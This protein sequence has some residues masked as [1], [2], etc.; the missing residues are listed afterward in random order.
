MGEGAAKRENPMKK[1]LPPQLML[2]CLLTMFPLHWFFPGLTILP[3]PFQ[4]VGLLPLFT[5]TILTFAAEGQVRSVGTNVKTFNVIES[6]WPTQKC[7][8]IL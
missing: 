2:V 1:F 4:L 8:N 7:S 5:G 6:P 3:T